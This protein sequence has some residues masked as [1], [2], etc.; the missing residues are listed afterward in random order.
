MPYLSFALV[1][2]ATTLL[3]AQEPVWEHWNAGLG[4]GP[5][6]VSGEEIYGTGEWNVGSGK[7]P[8]ATVV[9]FGLLPGDSSVEVRT[10]IPYRLI[11]LFPDAGSSVLGLSREGDLYRIDRTDGSSTLLGD[12]PYAGSPVWLP[13]P[14]SVET[15]GGEI[16][17]VAYHQQEGISDLVLIDPASSPTFRLIQFFEPRS[18]FG[19]E[20][21]GLH[22]LSSGGI[23]VVYRTATE[24]VAEFS[25]HTLDTLVVAVADADGARLG[26]SPLLASG[27]DTYRLVDINTLPDGGFLVSVEASASEVA[28]LSLVHFSLNDA[29]ELTGQPVIWNLQDSHW[30]VA[31]LVVTDGGD[32]LGVGKRNRGNF[33]YSSV[34]FRGSL[35]NGITWKEDDPDFIVGLRQIDRILPWGD[36]GVLISGTTYY[37]E[38][39]GEFYDSYLGLFELGAI[40]GVEDVRRG[41][42]RLDLD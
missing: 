10:D 40:S 1:L 31:D 14:L 37:Q 42:D 17:Y 38:P 39:G 28:G 2:F 32:I 9:D 7:T 21:E 5:L 8:Y 22:P 35:E 23:A 18:R 20:I 33:G 29:G 11:G 36:R 30:T 4:D 12:S 15:T 13:T 3:S 27:Y 19:A 41:G 34:I 6:L 24:Y 26:L 25:R 16:A